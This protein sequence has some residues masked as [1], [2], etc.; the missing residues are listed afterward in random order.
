MG[1]SLTIADKAALTASIAGGVVSGLFYSSY[2]FMMVF[3]IPVQVVFGRSGFGSGLIAAAAALLV[4]LVSQGLRLI[5]MGFSNLAGIV[6]FVIPAVVL[7]AA[8]T[9]MN[10]SWWKGRAEVFR[11]IGTSGLCAALVLPLLIVESRE[12]T[13]TKMLE[14]LITS[15]VKAAG[16]EN[17]ESSVLAVTIEPSEAARKILNLVNNSFAS[18]IFMTLGLSWMIGNRLA[19]E[20]SRG[21]TL[22]GPVENYRLPYPV[23]WIFLG[24][25]AAVL[26]V[27]V[28]KAP[29]FAAAAAWNLALVTSMVYFVQ[30]FGIAVF[31]MKKWNAPRALRIVA[32]AVFVTMLVTPTGGIAAITLALFGLSETWI[33]YRIV[34]E[35][36]NESNS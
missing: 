30:G 17:Y 33:P 18:S 22:C 28:L 7:L 25:W 1:R 5:Q 8:L 4:I 23:V 34:K 27:I 32:A 36:E 3:L 19:G 21:R 6:S 35:S 29:P 15:F 16:G 24:S 2:L 9:L 14:Q 12:G 11:V 20:G 26:A 31:L 13:V 10:A